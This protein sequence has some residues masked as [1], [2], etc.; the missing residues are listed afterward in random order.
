M[1]ATIR[2]LQRFVQKAAK[3][4]GLSSK[5]TRLAQQVIVT[6]ARTGSCRGSR[7]MS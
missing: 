3:A 2:R 7:L 6:M 4:A 5:D 1:G